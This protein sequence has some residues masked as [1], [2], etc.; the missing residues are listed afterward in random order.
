MTTATD[1]GS[2][3]TDNNTND[4]TPDFTIA[5]PAGHTATLYVDGVAVP[6]TLVAGVLTPTN[7]LPDGAHS[8]TT[9]ITDAAGNESAQSPSLAINID[10]TAP[11]APTISA[12]PENSNGGINAVED[13]NGTDIQVSIPAD[14]KA[15]DILTLSIGG[16]S[17]TYTL[18]AGDV[19]ST[20]TVNVPPAKLD[21]ILA[22]GT[23]PVTATLTDAAGNTSAPSA[24][25]DVTLDR[26]LPDAPGA[27]DL[28]TSS[29]SGINTTDDITNDTTP[30]I[31]GATVEPGATVTLFDTDGTT[32]LGST[33]ADGSGNWSITPSLPLTD[34]V[35]SF[36][37]KQTDIAGNTSPASAPLAVTIDTGA[38]A[39]P[40]APDM[41]TSSDTG[42]VSN[43]DYTN[44]TAPE[45]AVSVPASHT[46]SLYI[47]GVKVPATLAA[48]VLT[49][50]NPIPDGPH[51][52]TY[53]VTD[54][55]GNESGQ[56]PGLAITIDTVAAVSPAINRIPENAG[57]GVTLVEQGDGTVIVVDI[58][59]SAKVGDSLTLVIGTGGIAQTVVYSIGASDIGASANVPVSSL[60]LTG[61]GNNG[62]HSVVAT[63]TDQAGN[64]SAPSSAYPLVLTN[65][66]LTSPIVTAVPENNDGG[67]N[68]LEASNGTIVTVDVTNSQGGAGNVAVGDTLRV[69]INGV[70][71][72][73][74]LAS[75]TG[76]VSVFFAAGQLPAIGGTY[77]V[78][79]VIYSAPGPNPPFPTVP[80]LPGNVSPPFPIIFDFNAPAVPAVAPDLTPGSDTGGSDVD[81]KTTDTTPSFT[82]PAPGVGE[83]PSLYLNGAKIPSTFDSVANT[84]T[85]INP[86]PEGTYSVTY[87][88]TDAAGNE[89][90]V[91]PV[92]VNVVVD[93]TAPSAPTTPDMTPGTDSGASN[94]DNN[95]DDTTPSFAVAAPGVNET[96]KLYVDGVLV[97]STFDSLTNTIT[98]T[99]PLPD[100]LHTIT[101][102]ITDA[103]GNESPQS[104][105]LA[106]TIDTTASSAPVITAVPENS[107]GGVNAAEASDGTTI[108]VSI[109]ADANAG[110]ILTL[111][112]GGQPPFTYTVLAGDVGSTANVPVTAGLLTALPSGDVSVTATLTDAAG[113]TSAP[114]S[115]FTFTL[116][117]APPL[118]PTAL[119]LLA[120]SD[121]G[122]SSTDDNTSDNT[123]TITGAPVEA[124]ATVTLYDSN[125]TTVLGITVADGSGNWS[126]TSS[127]LVDG[128]HNFTVK[129][130]DTAGNQGAAS[131]VLPVTIDT[132]APAAPVAPDMTTATD[133]GTNTAD[134]NTNDTTPDF[135]VSVPASHTTKLYVDGVAVP[136]TLVGGVLTPTNPITDGAHTITYTVTDLA[137]N[138]STQSPSLAISIDT[139]AP[140]APTI[141]AAPEN[142]NGGINQ[143]EA[144]D[145][146]TIQVSIPADAKAGD[147]LTLTLDGAPAAQTVTYTVLA[148]DV[149][150]TATVPIPTGKLSPLDDGNVSVTATLTD[151]AGNISAPSASFDI[152]LDTTAP[153][154]IPPLPDL[155]APSDTGSSNTDNITNDTTPTF[156]QP[157][158]TAPADAVTVAVFV[159]G[160][161]TPILVGVNPDGSFSFN[162][163]VLPGG[164]HT[165]TMAYVDAV[166]NTGT[167][168][169]PLSFTIDTT[170]P[171]APIAPDMT[172]GTDSGASNTDNATNDTTPSFTVAAPAAGEV[173]KLYVDGV[174][175]ASTFD[176]LT[177]TLTP[178]NPLAEGPHNVTT[179]ITD[180]AGNESAQSPSLAINIDTTAPSVPSINAVP[181]N[182]N[183]GVNIAEASDGT[184]IQVSIPA[185]AKAGDILTMTVGGQPPFTYTVLAGDVGST[186]NVPV[187]AGLLTA[188]PS[189]DVSVTA[190][191]TDAAGNTSA[192]SSPFTFTLDKTPPLAP[193][194]LD[195][196]ASSDSG[197]SSTDDNTSDTTP[198]ITGAPVEA[199]ATVTLYDSDGTTV[200][201]TT[202]A[203]GSGNWSVTSSALTDGLHNFTVKQTDQAGNQGDA[204]P[205][206]AVTI[207][208]T[209][210]SA[211][212]APDMTTG[213]DSGASNTDNATNDT[214]PSFTVAAP[215]AGE[216]PKLYVD[217]VLVPSTFDSLTNTLT[218]TNP[219]PDGAHS[220]TTT[221]TDAAGNESAQSPSLAITIDTTAPSAPS[222]SAVPEN[223]NGGVNAA[224]ASDGTII[225][226]SIPVD[227]KVGDTL[228]LTVGGQ[229]VI[230]TILAS[231][232][233]S[234]ADVSVDAPTLALLAD[235]SIPVTATLTDAAGN[236]SAPSSPF[237]FIL[238]RVAPDAPGITSVPENAGGGINAN[239]G[240]DGTT[241]NISLPPGTKAGDTITLNVGGTPVSY[242]VTA[243]DILGGSSAVPVSASVLAS[244]V[245]PTGEGAVSLTATVTD[246]AGNVGPAS[247]SFSINVDLSGPAAPTIASVP[248]NTQGG[249]NVDEA[250]NGT[251]VNIDISGIG[252][253]AGDVLTLDWGGTPV[254]YTLTATDITN[255]SA[256]I[257]VSN[258]VINARGSGLFDLTTT[259]TDSAGNVSP[260]ST[261]FTVNVDIVP[262]H[263]PT[264]TA[265][266]ENADGGINAAEAADGT[267]IEVSL[268]GTDAKAGDFVHLNWNG[269]IIDHQLT[270]PEIDALTTIITVPF[271]TIQAAGDGTFP[272]V[273]ASITD[274]AGNPGPASVPFTVVVDTAAPDVPVI[275]SIPESAGGIGKAE[276]AD[277]T[278]VNVT[279]PSG[280]VAGDTVTLNFGGQ[281]ISYT[282]LAGDV[283]S[284]NAPIFVSK[285]ILETVAGGATGT[286]NNVPVTATVTDQAGNV[287]PSS[288]NFPVN[289]DFTDPAAP[290]ALD[291]T[292]ASD[293]GAINSDNITS[294]TTPTI[295]GAAVEPGATVTLY[296]SDGTTVIGTTVANG[297]GVWS[298]TPAT[299]LAPGVHNFT[300]KQTDTAG[301]QS[302]ASAPLAVTITVGAPE[303]GTPDMTAGTD[304]GS[305]STDN[306]T[307]DTTPDFTISGVD[308][309]TISVFADVNNDGIF[310]AGDIALGSAVVAGGI[311]TITAA[312]LTAG[313]YN[314]RATQTDLGGNVSTASSPLAITVDT[315]APST[316]TPALDLI[317][318]DDTGSSST[319]NRTNKTAYTINATGLEPGAIAELKEGATVIATVTVGA[320]GT[321]TFNVTGATTGAHNYTVTQTDVAGNASTTATLLTVTVDTTA[322]AA[323]APDLLAASDTGASS[324]D[325]IT[326]DDTP[327]ITGPAVEP[328]ATV[329]LYD[330]DGTT[331][332]GTAVADGAGA[333]SITPSTAL[334]PGVHNF[335]TKQT[336]TAG[337]TS[338]AS[339]PLAVTIVTTAPTP[340]TPDM[341]AGTD[342][343]SS[344]IDNI[345]ND[346]TPDFTISGVNGNTI[347][348]FADVNNDG[349]FNAGDIALGS[350][351]VSGGVATIT[352]TPALTAGNYNIR[353]TQTDLGGNVSTASSPLAITVDTV[354]PSTLTPALDL[355][356]ADDTGSSSTDN[357]TNKTAYTINATGLEPGATAELKEGAT[358]F[359][360]VTVGA[361]GTATFN[362]TGATTGAHNYTVTQ[363]DVAGNPS[364]TA[365]LLTVTVDTTAP[366]APTPDLLT[367]SDSGSSG[368]DNLTN[369]TTPTITGA[370]VEANATVTL[371]DSDGT[372]VL[373][374]TVADGSGNWSIT[375]SAALSPG[376]HNFTT[377]QT[378]VAGNQGA[379]ST[380][381]A[382]TIDTNG[383]TFSNPAAVNE[384]FTSLTLNGANLIGSDNVTA[385]GSLEVISAVFKSSSTFVAGDL[386]FGAPSGGAITMTRS[387]GADKNGTVV[388]TVQVRDAAGNV[389]TQD[390]TLT[391][392]SVND[393]PIGTNN[394]LAATEDTVLTLTS[395]NFG[396][397]DPSDTPANTLQGV[398]I[399]T[400][401][402]SGTLFVDANG[403]GIVDVGEAVAAGATVSASNIASGNLKY[404]GGANANGSGTGNF[405][406]QVQD[407]GGTASGGVDLDP[408]PRT[409]TVN[410]SA[411]ND[412]P[413][414]TL[415]SAVSVNEDT[416]LSFTAANLISVNDPDSNV[417]Q[418]LSSAQL[419]VG[420]G[421]LTVTLSGSAT[422]SAG[423]N[424]TGALTISGSQT[425]I[426][427]TLASLK[428]QGISNFNGSDTLT[429][430]SKDA[431]NVTDTDTVA[432]TV[433]SVNDAPAGADKTVGA[434][435]DTVFTFGSTD[436]GFTDSVEG[437]TLQGVKITTAPGAGTLFLDANANSV[438]DSGEAIAAG[439]TVS[440]TDIA[441]N[442]LRFIGA[443]NANGAP[444]TTFS[445]QVQ[446]NGGTANGGVDLDPSANT[447]TINVTAVNDAPTLDASKSPAI[448]TPEYVFSGGGDAG[449]HAPSGA[450]PTGSLLVS[451]LIDYATPSGQVDNA[452][453]V[454]TS[455]SLGL[456]VTALSANL[457][458]TLWYTTN[459]GTTWQWTSNT[460]D[461]AGGKG[462][463]GADGVAGGGDDRVLFLAADANTKII[464]D[465]GGSGSSTSLANAITFRAW[466]QTSGT[467]G[468]F[469][470]NP[471]TGGSNALSSSTDT[472]QANFTSQG[473]D[474]TRLDGVS[475]VAIVGGTANAKFG[476]D[477]GTAGDVNGDGFDDFIISENGVAA[478]G[479]GQAYLYYG[480]ATPLGSSTP[481]GQVLNAISGASATF[482]RTTAG[483]TMT[484]VTQLGDINADGF[485]DFMISGDSA[486]T[487]NGSAYIIFG[488]SGGVASVGSLDGTAAA[489]E[490]FRVSAANTGIGR[491]DHTVSFAGDVNGDGYSDLMVGTPLSDGNQ[492]NSGTTFVIYG[493]AGKSF[494]A[495]NNL[496]LG[497]LANTAPETLSD[498]GGVAGHVFDAGTNTRGILVSGNNSANSNIGNASAGLG[499]R[500]G[501]GYDDYFIELGSGTAAGA[502]GYIAFGNLTTNNGGN[503]LWSAGTVGSSTIGN[504]TGANVN[505]SRI[506]VTGPGS[507]T[508]PPTEPDRINM[509][510]LGDINGDGLADVAISYN[511]LTNGD[512]Y[513]N[514]GDTTVLN[515]AVSVTTLGSGTAG[516]KISGAAVGDRLGESIRTIGDFNGDGFD[517]FIV[518]APRNEV[519]T[520]TDQGGAYI[521]YGGSSLAGST[522]NLS[523]PLTTSQG[524]YIRGPVAGDQGGFSVASAGDV[525]GDGFDDLLIGAPLNDQG[526][527]DAGTAFLIYGATSYGNKGAVS[528]TSFNGTGNTAAVQLV[529][530]TS[531]ADTMSSGIGVSDAVSTGSGNDLII[532]VSNNFQ[533]VDGGTGTDTLRVTGAVNLDFTLVGGAGGNL[534]G[535][536]RSIEQIDL[537]SGN[538]TL[539]I[540]A[541]DVLNISESTNSLRV[542]GA[543]GDTLDLSEVIGSAASQWHN[544]GT[545]AGV[546]TY[547]YFDASNV[548]TLAQV[549]VDSL[550]TTS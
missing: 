439:T 128:L 307:F 464:Y 275:A 399:T 523:T 272:V 267:P 452:T 403:N 167:H 490:W 298:I 415:P 143:S 231:D 436:F 127:A 390:V 550:I 391:V 422:I 379:A 533:R 541:Q 166:G 271:T 492:A 36:T 235:G 25:F 414:N 230:Y 208:T 185:D 515:D 39:A 83:T 26:G 507:G 418:Q 549:L 362:V 310:N 171:S 3:N 192:P 375:P 183:G 105:S 79:A 384:G 446:D 76:P 17:V 93:T 75:N 59:S 520:S 181:E 547:Q 387:G 113:N 152:T 352:A 191:L 239:E 280:T 493:H 472:I 427:A 99:N 81:N 443:L 169:A 114:S 246:A 122:V 371:Y 412:A 72:D 488:K 288:V 178:M 540:N 214:T 250:A 112:I 137:G 13:N 115:P 111:T 303:P 453:D 237:S 524:L 22:D 12:V 544:L 543:A 222:I 247:P 450:S 517:D 361:G 386:S 56:S 69:T 522:I 199:G 394:T 277:G 325:N 329:T 188:L 212:I 458:T 289:I 60:A 21:A 416:S 332:L 252:A 174:L 360:T 356:A 131:A 448:S 318:A 539:R 372:T 149:G 221:I 475:G 377:K 442:K 397:T 383:P 323:P 243:G 50:N 55:A 256:P 175:V 440:A 57:G 401:P 268:V 82:I 132:T 331:V 330:S 497:T 480:Q 164:T 141:T 313:N 474:L 204:S 182:S 189:G 503:I 156:S 431:A 353:A 369:T 484:G 15:G 364:T 220:V 19:G 531:G 86:V 223:S 296:D 24:P 154:Q 134:N 176:S 259:L 529:V 281:I 165:I 454:D 308:G 400:T 140:T 209:K 203:D 340:G 437:N 4:T 177:N 251:I 266:S 242:V 97:P 249:I 321:A 233:G 337:N 53:S 495:T 186:A 180:V 500:N 138:E 125:G 228:N 445:F 124:G 546:T 1:S 261:P 9:T 302:T 42:I 130:T 153:S 234:T 74:V 291:L 388:V 462:L 282:V 542:S 434:V 504:G 195:L 530:G 7:P 421:N 300:T 198:T 538:Q 89:S 155:D 196:L 317:A 224:E 95:T 207:D 398:K 11:S 292:D 402:G 87:T 496:N 407:N 14:A 510:G 194:T 393:A 48:G 312:A 385:T 52:I 315:V 159:D 225:K 240:A 107:N 508:F 8:I 278:V 351:T 257:P 44:E 139:T 395:A 10:T 471:G 133:S 368:I 305:F 505:N 49:P 432:I 43:D 299:A 536:V 441:A 94:T 518:G 459:G 210:P 64:V 173:P 254:S 129:Q 142:S 104:P 525:N 23:Y 260:P 197:V 286:A 116:D 121:S 269:T 438:F 276:A 255:L 202:V 16:Q 157:A 478:T 274:G 502:N 71:S 314:I 322:P 150:A 120:S 136:A 293:T 287:S 46:A 419:S 295:T 521:V 35:H 451:S 101:T 123:P 77:D 148:G 514:F 311:A 465:G 344:S 345:T 145:G 45:F 284:G 265:I 163:G 470:T 73:I 270:Q 336:D 338:P 236:T 90:G 527:A 489:G 158:G 108:Q 273:V 290:T 324:I 126:I 339:T 487:G 170:A 98:P 519:G 2:N 253:K 201:G 410:V 528:V 380:P 297:S 435:E 467:A 294:D 91:S 381:L 200:I 512:V 378:D 426:N 263:A 187:T 161:V 102:T 333:W 119:D 18:L 29:D 58:P 342:S 238:D 404:L 343:G 100:G 117:K 218:P 370:A 211:P 309:N 306:I 501:D 476:W 70:T 366:A 217:G 473:I 215:A 78:T 389:T 433:N 227:A 460:S 347:S 413:I 88:L 264:I 444:Y 61:L 335:T 461:S 285:A 537:G 20:A 457:G 226:V 494:G 34:G 206:L 205:V 463:F 63:I 283:G 328:G 103:A 516:F 425:D 334:S 469:L 363:T 374:T 406:F 47:D 430:T 499:D 5:V 483:E 219:L 545:S 110:D 65:V 118:A 509:E 359:A 468:S 160:S 31:S 396:F 355:I 411:V 513:V 491:S 358:V 37:T 84:L 80:G 455:P 511:W 162:S 382:V 172:A 327:T 30:T 429:I 92:L 54:P 506:R 405:T 168:S 32:V 279:L 85:P 248:E 449:T 532:V 301:N 486:T 67:I 357:R 392:N 316:A 258:A 548:A 28:I 146:T 147:I 27:L 481:T 365:T 262:P 349:V 428:Y 232:I 498:T 456:G 479:K 96:P 326:N 40:S 535:K 135:T 190:T 409:M 417:G 33:V 534:S 346:P 320:G 179:T 184:A 151:A 319:D 354:A 447:I 38:P 106:I 68:A 350:A 244:A 109:P 373:G 241:V 376:V 526:A 477:V 348:V 482:T 41:A 408:T 341:T 367:A 304:S 245:A 216:T 62:V 485:A 229:P 144:S 51:T 213:T 66:A 423:T 6:A 193:T 466:D 424:G 420:S